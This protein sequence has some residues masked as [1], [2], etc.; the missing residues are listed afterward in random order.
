MILFQSTFVISQIESGAPIKAVEAILVNERN[1]LIWYSDGHRE[2]LPRNE[3][4]GYRNKKGRVY[5]LY[6]KTEQEAVPEGNVITCRQETMQTSVANNQAVAV[7]ETFYG[8]TL[9]SR[10]FSGRRKTLQNVASL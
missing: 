9:D 2:K 7:T 8:E 10:I 3:I 1:A 6:S 5:R 4:W